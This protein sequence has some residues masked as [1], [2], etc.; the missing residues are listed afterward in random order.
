MTTMD[1]NGT[2]LRNRCT[3]KSTRVK[4]VPLRTKDP[5]IRKA[6]MNKKTSTPPDTRPDVHR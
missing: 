1:A 2:S 6:E 3:R 5:V 4:A